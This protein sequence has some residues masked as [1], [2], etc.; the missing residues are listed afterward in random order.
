MV[1]VTSHHCDISGRP[2]RLHYLQL[3]CAERILRKEDPG[4]FCRAN[5]APKLDQ[6]SS[7]CSCCLGSQQLAEVR[8]SEGRRKMGALLVGTGAVGGDRGLK[9]VY[10]LQVHWI[11]TAQSSVVLSITGKSVCHN[12]VST[13][14]E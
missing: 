9:S 1:Q 10:R 7:G 14:V 6:P 13:R 8:L 4:A 11:P 2:L 5:K 3:G 12:N